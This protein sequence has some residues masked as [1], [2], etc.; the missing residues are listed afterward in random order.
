MSDG[1]T[2]VVSEANMPN[3]TSQLKGLKVQANSSGQIKKY[4]L[5]ARKGQTAQANPATLNQT[6]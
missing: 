4:L 6:L 3:I 2:F 1:N 5:S